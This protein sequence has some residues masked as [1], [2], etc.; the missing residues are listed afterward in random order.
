M[1]RQRFTE[2]RQYENMVNQVYFDLFEE[3]GVWMVHAAAEAETPDGEYHCLK[4]ALEEVLADRK[5]LV[6]CYGEKYVQI[7]VSNKRM[8]RYF[9]LIAEVF[10]EEDGRVSELNFMGRVVYHSI[11]ISGRHIQ[12]SRDIQLV[13]RHFLLRMKEEKL[14]T[15]WNT[16][17]GEAQPDFE[18][19]SG[20]QMYLEN[21]LF[22]IDMAFQFPGILKTIETEYFES[23]AE[24]KRFFMISTYDSKLT[25]LRKIT[26]KGTEL[27]EKINGVMMNEE[28]ESVV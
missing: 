12:N 8:Y 4:T 11:Y 6:D 14:A 13:K 2:E 1:K 17:F 24:F 5:D 28:E 26:A 3:E 21:I 10:E 22:M 15:L 25:A 7:D 19:M 18:I 23:E 27:M 9:P 20:N 16:V